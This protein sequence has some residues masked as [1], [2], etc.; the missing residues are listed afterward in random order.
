[1][2]AWTIANLLVY[3]LVAG[4]LL[5][6]SFPMGRRGLD[7]LSPVFTTDLNY[8][9]AQD[10]GII[11]NRRQSNGASGADVSHRDGVSDHA[12]VFFLV[13]VGFFSVSLIWHLYIRFGWDRD[14]ARQI[15]K[16]ATTAMEM[17][18][19]PSE[20]PSQVESRRKTR[21]AGRW[22]SAAIKAA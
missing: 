8:V 1:M 21:G 20:G 12:L 7:T 18:R 6:A 16:A 2:A 19:L 10:H 14:G 15:D 4:S 5:V 11:L 9:S 17:D 22:L 13:A 3:S